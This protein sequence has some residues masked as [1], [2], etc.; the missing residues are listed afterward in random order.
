M[1]GRYFNYYQI[2]LARCGVVMFRLNNKSLVLTSSIVLA[3]LF[4]I[5]IG[6][7]ETISYSSLKK[8][9]ISEITQVG[10]TLSYQMEAGEALLVAA[11]DIVSRGETGETDSTMQYFKLQLDQMVKNKMVTN[12]YVYMPEILNE[13]GAKVIVA[14]QTNEALASSG[15]GPGDKYEMNESF[16]Q[17]FQDT[18]D[19]GSAL[20][21]IVRDE[22]GVW[23]SYL[24]SIRNA[25]GQLLGVFGVDVDYKLV[26]ERLNQL[27]WMSIS[28]AA[29]FSAIAIVI[30]VALIR[31][32]LKPLKRLSE[33]AS[34]AAQGDLTVSV[35]V[36]GGNE[37]AQVSSAFNEMIGSL[38]GLTGSIRTTSGEV[39]ASALHMQQ[40]AEQTSRATEDVTTA[41]QEVASGSDTQL[42]S[43]QECQRAMNE[44]TIG[45]QR[46]AESAA[47]VSELA[48]DT[49]QLASEG[50]TVIARTLQQM[51]TI[52]TNV[53]STVS[54]LQ[55]L[56][57]QSD[58]ISGILA[59]IG[60]VANQTNLLALNASIE[61]ARAGEHGKGFAVVAHEIRKLAE[62]SKESSSEI[63]K[64]LHSIGSYAEAAVGAMEKSVSAAREGSG[65][66]A[67][68][69]SSFRAIVDSIRDVSTQVQEVSAASEQMSAGSEQIAASLD[70]LEGITSANAGNSQ[71]V[72]AAS[73]EQLASMQEVA[74]SADQLRN[75]ATSLTEA[76]GRFKA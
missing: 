10:E 50:E 64:I 41:I 37:I 48:T 12:A 32:A 11:H 57:E 63:E 15:L 54:T 76:V 62:R 51:Q 45:I 21:S 19:K 75:L 13:N 36:K 35:P 6:I 71:R 8:G 42:Q 38:R 46:I 29:L 17:T 55:E 60:D 72:A 14:M 27:L 39:S 28:I 3:V 44:M 2:L 47:T 18:I 9:A 52:E 67:E 24:T 43:F 74:S 65:I 68:A 7:I 22:Y 20:S 26:E 33:V 16:A 30:A 59:M 25:D 56:K 70:E 69:G 58:K 34:Q 73:E 4:V 23:I 1:P 31:W 49:N 53:S 40:S 66:S 61:A 5:V